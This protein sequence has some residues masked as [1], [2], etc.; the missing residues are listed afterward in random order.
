MVDIRR[1]GELLERRSQRRRRA[2]E[3]L[4]AHDRE[5]RCAAV[6]PNTWQPAVLRVCR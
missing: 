2:K 1:G 3:W 6:M 5:A 4:F